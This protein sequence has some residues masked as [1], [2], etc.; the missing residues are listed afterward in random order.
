LIKIKK[1][2]DEGGSGLNKGGDDEVI[3]KIYTEG[4]Y[5]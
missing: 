1:E 3:E 5:K 4:I 2:R